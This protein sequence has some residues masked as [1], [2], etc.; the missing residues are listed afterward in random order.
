MNDVQHQALVHSHHP[1]QVRHR[2]RNKPGSSL[3]AD[4]V[5]GGIDGCVTT[6]AVVAGAYGAGFPA[7]VA[8]VL[9]FANLLADG[10]SM[11][12]SN[13]ESVR[14]QQEYIDSIRR[15]EAMHI[16]K[17][18]EG[19][20]EEVRQIF[21]AKG[22]EG[23]VLEEIVATIT[24]DREVWINTMLMEEYGLQSAPA[25]PWRAA[26]TTL[27]AFIVVGMVPLLPLL[28]SALLP[29]QQFLFSSVL[30]AVMFLAVGMLKSVVL[31]RPVLRS[32]LQTLATGGTAATLAFGAGA[33]L[34]SVFGIDSL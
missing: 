25:N 9:G 5:L 31:A 33:L 29:A 6:F 27:S 21:A 15:T 17:V 7:L 23:A 8:L 30:A 13:Y 24:R 18:P 4:A 32:G 34:R 12:V 1:E 10:F 26:I 2:L 22:F 16:D 3:V 19:E 11:A 20:R 28:V 14:A